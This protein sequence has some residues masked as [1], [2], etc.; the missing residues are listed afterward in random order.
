MQCNGDNDDQN[1]GDNEELQGTQVEVDAEQAALLLQKSL[2][3][4]AVQVLILL[5]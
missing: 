1:A 2:R 3:G 4:R 5:H